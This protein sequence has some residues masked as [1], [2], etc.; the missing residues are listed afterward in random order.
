MLIARPTSTDTPAGT[1]ARFRSGVVVM[2]TVKMLLGPRGVGGPACPVWEGGRVLGRVLGF[3]SLAEGFQASRGLI[4]DGR[5]GSLPYLWG[6]YSLHRRK[7][8][9]AWLALRVVFTL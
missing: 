8:R 5:L 4:S 2:V 9:R 6:P 3:G 7:N 1:G